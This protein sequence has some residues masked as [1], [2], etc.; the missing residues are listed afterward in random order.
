MCLYV[1]F[2]STHMV[3]LFMFKATLCIRY[4]YFV[5]WSVFHKDIELANPMMSHDYEDHEDVFNVLME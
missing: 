4:G 3:S 1:Y 5:Y 2:S